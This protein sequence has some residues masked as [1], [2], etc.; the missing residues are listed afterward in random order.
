MNEKYAHIISWDVMY[1]APYLPLARWWKLYGEFT[2]AKFAA[3]AVAAAA[4]FITVYFPFNGIW[5]WWCE[6]ETVWAPLQNPL[7]YEFE[8][9]NDEHEEKLGY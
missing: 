9:K 3:A 7:V 2:A 1:H 6:S 4:W 8:A 5:W